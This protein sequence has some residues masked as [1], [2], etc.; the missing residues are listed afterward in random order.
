[1]IAD[2]NLVICQEVIKKDFNENKEK[3][4]H[5]IDLRQNRK[6]KDSIYD[7]LLFAGE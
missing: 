1:M 2:S 3:R 6:K 7:Y 5:K 4:V